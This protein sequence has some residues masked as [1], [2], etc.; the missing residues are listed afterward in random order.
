[1]RG[2]RGE[3]AVRQKTFAL[4]RV[5]LF[6]ERFKVG[7]KRLVLLPQLAKP[8][9]TLAA[10]QLERVIEQRAQ[11]LPAFLR[12]DHVLRERTIALERAMEVQAR[13]FPVALNRAL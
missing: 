10:L 4:D 12:D 7:S 9:Q 3:R 13:L 11:R 8:C 2:E 1:M 6:E 5:A